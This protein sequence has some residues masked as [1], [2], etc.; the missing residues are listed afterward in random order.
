MRP[1]LPFV[2]GSNY[3]HPK[4]R[5]NQ[6]RLVQRVIACVFSCWKF[7][8]CLSSAD[9]NQPNSMFTWPQPNVVDH[10]INDLIPTHTHKPQPLLSLSLTN[11]DCGTNE[12][13]CCY[14]IVETVVFLQQFPLLS[15]V[16]SHWTLLRICACARESREIQFPET[17]TQAIFNFS[18][19]STA[20]KMCCRDFRLRT[21][22]LLADDRKIGRSQESHID[23]VAS[24][25][26]RELKW[27]TWMGADKQPNQMISDFSRNKNKT[28]T[29]ADNE[30]Y[31]ELS[32]TVDDTKLSQKI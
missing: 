6:S 1:F 7:C 13:F 31:P 5:R 28:N 27:S 3:C 22:T 21:G 17:H 20:M 12:I 16:P 2:D 25:R 29:I 9:K 15:E 32:Q 19:R 14:S 4:C 23:F 11:V 8:S 30:W 26:P 18:L 24:P 10:K